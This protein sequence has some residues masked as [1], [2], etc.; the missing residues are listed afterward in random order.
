MARTTRFGD[1]WVAMCGKRSGPGS[2]SARAGMRIFLV[3]RDGFGRR[4]ISKMGEGMGAQERPAS[5]IMVYDPPAESMHFVRSSFLSP[6]IEKWKIGSIAPR[7]VGDTRMGILGCRAQNG[8]ETLARLRLERLM[9]AF[10][11]P[12]EVTK[13]PPNSLECNTLKDFECCRNGKHSNGYPPLRGRAS[14]VVE[15]SP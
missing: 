12:C 14:V 7:A 11:A 1:T 2:E 3:D 9:Y 5:T 10:K 13:T 8:D 15:R 6:V 4:G